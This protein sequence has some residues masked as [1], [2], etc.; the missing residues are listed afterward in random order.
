[1]YQGVGDQERAQGIVERKTQGEEML[2]VGWRALA[3]R[4]KEVGYLQ[5]TRHYQETVVLANHF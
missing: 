2:A 5:L 3:M 4:G 1:M